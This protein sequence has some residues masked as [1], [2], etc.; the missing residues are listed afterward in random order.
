MSQNKHKHAD[1][2]VVEEPDPVVVEEPD[3]VVVEEPDPVVVEESD[4]VVVE[5]PVPATEPAPGHPYRVTKGGRY[6]MAGHITKLPNGALVTSL[7]HDFAD[8][9]AQGI[10]FAPA[11]RVVTTEGQLGVQKS[12]VE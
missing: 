6:V 11:T 3:P 5:E 10:E 7:T 12:V 4:P 1:P 8:L 2:V 9:R